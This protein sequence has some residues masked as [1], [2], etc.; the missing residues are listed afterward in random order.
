MICFKRYGT[1]SVPGCI[2]IASNL[3]TS[4]QNY[5][6]DI[7]SQNLKTMLDSKCADYWLI[8]DRCWESDSCNVK[9]GTCHVGSNQKWYFSGHFLKTKRDDK[10][11]EYRTSGPI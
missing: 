10:C 4:G 8:P 2:G 7:S 6:A 1:E 3:A 5:C 11:M 9:M